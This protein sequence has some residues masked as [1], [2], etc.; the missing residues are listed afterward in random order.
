MMENYYLGNGRKW[1]YINKTVNREIT[2]KQ[3]MN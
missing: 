1:T 2:D 3:Q